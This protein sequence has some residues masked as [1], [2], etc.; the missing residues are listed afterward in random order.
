MDFKIKHHRNSIKNNTETFNFYNI[1]I[2][3]CQKYMKCANIKKL[4]KKLLTYQ[5]NELLSF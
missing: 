2:K 1:T 3:M 4:G 5:T